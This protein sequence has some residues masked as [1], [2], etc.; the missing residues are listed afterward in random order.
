MAGP[1]SR[2]KMRKSVE[3]SRTRT[4]RPSLRMDSAV[5]SEMVRMLEPVTVLDA[6]PPEAVA[7]PRLVAVS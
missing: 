7:M 3:P 4:P 1:P 6:T 5:F 2:V